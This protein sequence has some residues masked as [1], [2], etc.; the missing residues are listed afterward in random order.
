M[1]SRPHA[2]LALALW[3]ALLGGITLG[4]AALAL[5]ELPPV[6]PTGAAVALELA[7]TLPGAAQAA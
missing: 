7:W 6:P 3:S 1:T 2:W 5:R 4:M